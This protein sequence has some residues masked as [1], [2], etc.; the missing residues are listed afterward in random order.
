LKHAFDNPRDLTNSADLDEEEIED[1]FGAFV[2]QLDDK[3]MSKIDVFMQDNSDFWVAHPHRQNSHGKPLLVCLGHDDP[4]NPDGTKCTDDNPG[5]HFLR[6]IAVVLG[7][8]WARGCL[9]VLAQRCS[10]RRTPMHPTED[11]IPI[12]KKLRLSGVLHSLDIRLRQAVDDDLAHAEFLLRLLTDE[13]ERRDAKQLDTRLRKA[14]FEHRKSLE[15]FDFTLHL[16]SKPDLPAMPASTS[17]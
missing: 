5:T 7:L 17:Q 16:Q 13:V 1:E 11:L 6:K 8:S 4:D 10:D 12:L 9:F 15:D 3:D 2:S 14:R